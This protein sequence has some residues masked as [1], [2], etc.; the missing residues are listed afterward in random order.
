MTELQ[1][2]SDSWRNRIVGRGSLN[3]KQIKLN[4]L[5][6]RL[7]P[8]AQHSAMLGALE[9]IGWVSDVIVNKR[10]GNL[11]DGHLRVQLAK[12]QKAKAVPVSY[13]DLS[14]DEERVVL[15]TFDPITGLADL[16]RGKFEELL[17]GLHLDSEGLNEMLSN[18]AQEYGVATGQG[19]TMDFGQFNN[20]DPT[21]QYRL[22]VDGM[23]LSEAEA[24]ND[25]M[26]GIGRVEQ[27]RE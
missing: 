26:G 13:V 25:K 19:E 27:Y 7:H 15:A 2:K 6:W 5:N 4:P 9:E 23:T 16:D 8:W 22:I 12:A 20:A 11:V 14:E 18:M 3:P 10:T 24:L 21:L 17:E 1:E